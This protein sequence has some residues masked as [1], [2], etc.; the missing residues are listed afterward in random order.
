MQ[1]YIFTVFN[2]P[3]DK[4]KPECGLPHQNLNKLHAPDQSS[5]SN[6]VC[7]NFIFHG[8]RSF[9]EIVKN[10]WLSSADCKGR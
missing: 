5:V 8:K 10:K 3:D 4:V 6:C 9:V 1:F 7:G 2:I